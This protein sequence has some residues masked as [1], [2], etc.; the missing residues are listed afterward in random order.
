MRHD[1]NGRAHRRGDSD[2][3]HVDALNRG[4]FQGDDVID[5]RLDVFR[6]FVGVEAE[7]ADDAVDDA[8][9]VVAE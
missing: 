9:F 1:A 7:F 3:F 2:R 5:E 6:Q 8:A 4:R